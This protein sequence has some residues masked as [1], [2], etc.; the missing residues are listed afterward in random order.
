MKNLNRKEPKQRNTKDAKNDII[1]LEK[2]EMK[3]RN[4]IRIIG[5]AIEV[6]RI[7][8]TGLLESAYKECF[9]TDLK[10]RIHLVEKEKPM[11][12]SI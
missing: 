8:R 6:N 4:Q 9:T 5:F 1:K 10:K 11:P 2:Y 12:I 3:M 7:S